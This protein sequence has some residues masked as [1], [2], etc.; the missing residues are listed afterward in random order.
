MGIVDTFRMFF[1]KTKWQRIQ[2][3]YELTPLKRK[4]LIVS[5]YYYD[6]EPRTSLEDPNDEDLSYMDKPD[7]LFLNDAI[8]DTLKYYNPNSGVFDVCIDEGRPAL[9]DVGRYLSRFTF[10]LLRSR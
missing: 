7:Y 6:D 1:G 9:F 3:E 10:R 8:E 2:E 5:I 4:T